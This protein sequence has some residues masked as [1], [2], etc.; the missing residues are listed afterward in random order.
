MALPIEELP[1]RDLPRRL[2]QPCQAG[3][4]E[5]FGPTD[6]HIDI[7]RL[8]LFRRALK[9]RAFQF[10]LI[11]PNQMI[12]WLV[13]VTGLFGA[14]L[15]TYNFSTVIT[16]YIWFSVVF[17]LMVGVGRGWCAM[18][19]F[20]GLGEWVQRRTFWGRHPV[21]IGLGLRWPRSLARWAILPSVAMFLGLTWFEEF[22]NM[23]GPGNPRFTS[24]LVLTVIGT[25]VITFLVFERRTFC[26]YLCPLTALIGTVGAT[27]MVAGFR[28]RNRE[29]C[30]TCPTKDCMRGSERGYP[31]PWYEWPGSATSNLMCGLCTECMKNCPYDNVGLF[32]QPPLTSVIAP[33]RRR[34]DIACAAT[35]LFGLVLF[36]QVN[37][38]PVYA[39]LDNWL[40]QVTNFPGYPNPIDFLGFVAAASLLFVAVVWGVRRVFANPSPN[41][42]ARSPRRRG[43]FTPWFTALGYGLIPLMG[44][45]YLARQVPKFLLHA[46]RIVPA[47]SD[48]FAL[49]WNL[50]GTANSPLYDFHLASGQWL[51]VGQL[52]VTGLGTLAAAY[53]T[54]RIA[55]RDLRPLTSRVAWLRVTSAMVPLVFGVGVAALYLAIGGAE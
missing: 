27:G 25:A 55:G 26:R 6:P 11:L 45:D 39:A 1:V 30:I 33:V 43:S 36:Q 37:A 16:W 54:W 23:A 51:V 5:H 17:L 44:A 34:I 15:P 22:L 9:S 8:P 13:I 32:L 28:T 7:S 10:F 31:C 19:P 47:I 21:S 4:A 52:I 2:R 53:A 20:G 38:L 3:I 50:F 12:F 35:I 29:L 46:P 48:P 40:N 18:C 41:A 24:Y 49:G 14:L 42:D